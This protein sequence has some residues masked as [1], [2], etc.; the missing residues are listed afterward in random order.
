MRR[1]LAG[2]VCLTAACTLV[3][4]GPPA[5]DA[6]RSRRLMV[7]V[8]GVLPA[9]VPDTFRVRRGWGGIHGAV[10]IVAP[11]G[12]PVVSA[13]DGRVL[14]LRRNRKGGI[15]LYATDPTQRFI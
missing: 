3:H 6:L 5:G 12:T 10:D 8:A 7:P 14:R 15:T 13:D 4:R 1:A 9:D 11:R 2:A